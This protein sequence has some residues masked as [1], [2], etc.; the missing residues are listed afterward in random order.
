MLGLA[1]HLFRINLDEI[2]NNRNN[3]K[4]YIEDLKNLNSRL[5]QLINKIGDS[6]QG[7]AS[8]SYIN[9]MRK[10]A[11]QARQMEQVLE[12]FD[13]YADSAVTRFSKTDEESANSIKNSF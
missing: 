11:D 3:L 6:W 13:K 2:I 1:T 10:Y 7:D 12:E 5:E 9:M 4:K 8:T